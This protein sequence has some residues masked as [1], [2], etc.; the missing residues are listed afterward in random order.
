MTESKRPCRWPASRT[1]RTTSSMAASKA[2]ATACIS[3]TRIVGT[4]PN[5][6]PCW[7]RGRCSSPI[8]IE[9]RSFRSK[10]S[11]TC[12]AK[13]AGCTSLTTNPTDLGLQIA[14]GEHDDLQV[15]QLHAL[16]MVQRTVCATTDSPIETVAKK[17]FEPEQLKVFDSLPTDA[18]NAGIHETFVPSAQ[19]PAGARNSRRSGN[20]SAMHWL[21]ALRQ[22]CFAGWPAEDETMPR[23]DATG[24]GP[25]KSVGSV[26]F[27]LTTSKASTISRC[28][29]TCCC[30]ADDAAAELKSVG[31]HPLDEAGWNVF[32][33]RIA[34]RICRIRWPRTRR[35]ANNVDDETPVRGNCA[36]SILGLAFVAPRGIGRTAWNADPAKQTQIRRRFMLLGQTLDGMRVW[37]VR[38]ALQALRI[39][40]WPANVPAAIRRASAKWPA[41]RCTLRC[42][43]RN[44]R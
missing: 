39:D 33:R 22:K 15:L 38:R 8:P 25:R 10:V 21:T 24:R 23:N 7:H 27:V 32:H 36:E 34:R 17:Y 9:T 1:W 35:H 37:D 20:R 28:A 3:S 4:I 40:R 12:T 30:P 41:S 18:I 31:L 13:H 43:S 6:L 29:C 19:T 16:A 11:S 2:I 14:A 42:S 5:L 26:S 44:I